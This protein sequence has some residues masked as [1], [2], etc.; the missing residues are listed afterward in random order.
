MADSGAR[1]AARSRPPSWGGTS[2]ISAPATSSAA[3]LF[4]FTIRNGTLAELKSERGKVYAEKILIVKT[5][6]V[7]PT[8]FHF[9]KMEDIINRGGGN[10]VVQLWNADGGEGLA[11]TPRARIHGRRQAHPAGRG[12][13]DLRAGRVGLLPQRVY[14]RFWGAD[15]RHR[16]WSARSAG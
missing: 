4:C 13:G 1:S 9:Q 8:H 16:S 15:G 7:T 5:G 10:L 3:G 12:G 6:Q 2:P 14:H 11:R